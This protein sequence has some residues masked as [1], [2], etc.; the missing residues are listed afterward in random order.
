MWVNT[1]IRSEDVQDVQEDDS[2][3]HDSERCEACKAGVCT[4]GGS[5]WY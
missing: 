2:A 1:G 3:P 4:A 5:S